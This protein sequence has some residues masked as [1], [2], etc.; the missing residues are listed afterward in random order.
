[1]MIR[2]YAFHSGRVQVPGWLWK[3]VYFVPGQLCCRCTVGVAP[4]SS[5]EGAAAEAC[6]GHSFRMA[7]AILGSTEQGAGGRQDTEG[8]ELSCADGSPQPRAGTFGCFGSKEL[9]LVFDSA[10]IFSS[11]PS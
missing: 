2:Q 8:R 4:E 10:G 5:L 6:P 11:R 9:D 7:Q 3:R 1:M